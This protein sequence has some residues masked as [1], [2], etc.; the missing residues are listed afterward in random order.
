MDQVTK[1]LG[2]LGK[3][4]EIKLYEVNPQITDFYFGEIIRESERL[5]MLF[6][7]ANPDSELSEL[8][9]KRELAVSDEL[10]Y[11][12]NKAKY[13]YEITRGAFDLGRRKSGFNLTAGTC[14]PLND[15]IIKERTIIISCPDANLDLGRL[16]KGHIVDR[17]LEFMKQLG[18]TSGF[19]STGWGMKIY[20][21]HIEIIEVPIPS[22]NIRIPVALE[23]IS[24]SVFNKNGNNP[25]ARRGIISAVV[26][27]KN[28]L[29][30]R[31][32]ALSIP[33]L[34]TDLS[35]NILCRDLSF[36]ALITDEYL[37][38]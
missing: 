7:P 25:H 35:S 34:G 17:L 33:A 11:L 23:N 27:S 37:K 24:I 4:I 29:D 26:L 15:I 16:A 10:F 3:D 19:I 21:N 6:D 9:K 5:Q 14:C 28:L 1:K 31:A 30:S 13:F 18:I 22:H 12:I 36:K 8:N 20:G 2:L 32:A 38:K